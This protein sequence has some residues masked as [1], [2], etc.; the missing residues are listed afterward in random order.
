MT[1]TARTILL[2]AIS[3]ETIGYRGGEKMKD[4][5]Y[6]SY[7]EGFDKLMNK[8]IPFYMKPAKK[9]LVGLFLQ[10]LTDD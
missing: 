10:I 2:F 4:F 7:P 8:I 5:D 1:A 3:L 6:T 9:M